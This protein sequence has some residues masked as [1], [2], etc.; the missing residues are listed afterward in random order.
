MHI[1]QLDE[2]GAWEADKHEIRL[3]HWCLYV[4]VSKQWLTSQNLVCR[5]AGVSE[6]EKVVKLRDLGLACCSVRVELIILCSTSLA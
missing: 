2:V 3:L 5:G 6:R 1:K 4:M